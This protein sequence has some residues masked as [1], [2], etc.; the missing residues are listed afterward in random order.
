MKPNE[1]K[2]KFDELLNSTTPEEQFEH[3]AQLLAFKFLSIIDAEMEAQNISKKALA[4]KVGTSQSFITQLFRGDRKPNWTILA[5]MQKE[6]GLQF[7]ISTNNEI[8]QRVIEAISLAHK[9]WVKEGCYSMT[10]TRKL[11]GN[12]EVLTNPKDVPLAS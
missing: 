2:T 7:T 6:L 9:V 10:E 4:E 11:I 5:K 3:E 1:I 12:F 8:E